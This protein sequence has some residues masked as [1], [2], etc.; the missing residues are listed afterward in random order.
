MVWGPYWDDFRTCHGYAGSR[1]SYAELNGADAGS[2]GK[3]EHWVGA[4]VESNS[5]V[6]P[7]GQAPNAGTDSEQCTG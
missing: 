7:C 6:A 2:R 1:G 3:S 4:P 5:D